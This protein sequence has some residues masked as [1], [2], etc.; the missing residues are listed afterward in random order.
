M[1]LPYPYDALA[2]AV[3]DWRGL[4]APE[5]VEPFAFLEDAR[6]PRGLTPVE[7]CSFGLA[8]VRSAWGPGGL[9]N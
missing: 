8:C 4:P 3:H 5:R 7:P 9:R 2:P 6:L 1:S